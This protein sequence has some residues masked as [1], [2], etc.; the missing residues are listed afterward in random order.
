MNRNNISMSK[1]MSALSF[2]LLCLIALPFCARANQPSSFKAGVAS[3]VITPDEPMWMAGY[4]ARNKPSEGKVHDLHAKALALE[5]EQGTRLVI[6][7]VE[8]IGIP[9]PMRDWL[10]EHAK[11]AYKLEPELLLL[12][13]SH[14]HCGPVIRETRYSIYGNTLYG[15][16]PEQIR[17]SNKYVD[18]LQKKLLDLI[19]RAIENLAPAKLSYT[20]ARAGFAMNRRLITETG[21][22][23]SPNPEG[24]VDHDVP[25]L[26][27]DNPEGK[28]RAVLFGYACHCTTLS[29][30][31]YCGDYAGFAQEYIE[32]A[33]PGTTAMF[34][35]G[36]GGDQNPY[37]RRALDHCKHHG[38][39]LANGVET[40]FQYQGHQINGPIEA[41]VDTVMLDFA[42][43][44]S[45]EQLE[46]K[47]KSKDKYDRRHA[48]VLLEELE[49]NGKIRT[50]YPY[51]V[52]VVRFGE[53]LTMVALA[54]EVVV[55][56]SLRLK[57]ELPGRT[58]WVAGY[59]NDV[60]GYIPSVRVLREGGYEAGGAMRYTDLPGP[61]APSV[62]Q[63]VV[64]KVH[65]LVN[66][67]QTSPSSWNLELI[68][69]S[70]NGSGFVHA[71]SGEKFVA[72]GFNY[73]HDDSGR[74]LEDYWHHEWPTI[75][76][77]FKEIKELGA[78]VVRIH[79]QVSKFIQTPTEP[80]QTSLEQLARLVELAER[81]GLYLDITGL[82]CYHK[83]DVPEW[84][85]AMDEAARWNVQAK[86]WEAIA[87]TCA[88]SP[89]IFCYDLMNE[90]ILPGAE[91]AETDWLA[92]EFGGKHFVQRI[93]LDL[94]GRT[95]EQ[96]ARA[97]VDK[98]VSAIRKHDQRHMITV[99]VI[100]WAHTF[101]NAKPLF[102]SS[103]VGSN[104][105]FVSVHFYPKK[106]EVEKALTA[107]AVYDVGKPLVIEET[108][109]LWCGQDDFSQFF[110]GSREIADGWIGF[111]WGT[112][113][114]EYAQRKNDIAA[115][116][117][118]EWLEF[119][120][121]KTP[122][123]LCQKN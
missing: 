14:T 73:D 6:V 68:R 117:M 88:G 17:Q 87:K 37:P 19:G 45:R 93:T 21:V 112:T 13:A 47:A 46:Q 32:Q 92:G 31:Q 89:A 43:P 59:S 105:D 74:L 103:Q 7:T 10:A 123:I 94:A 33:H 56:Y 85:D 54:G 66:K 38:R 100:P 109:P 115:G 118:R 49:K 76:E 27:I 75:V 79:P 2:W 5:D 20:H 78:N 90:P 111:Y 77:D 110:N 12:N 1:I 25:V 40:A 52:Q 35:A 97:W 95:R 101:P 65:E 70:K 53:D 55:D 72:W 81:T 102:Y 82:G 4:A 16:S 71:G 96:V 9:R 42:E 36:C 61:F 63:R 98:L 69:P 122:E 99:G 57:S 15:L 18:D 84:Y 39:A 3:I 114:D 29:F 30:Y 24:P 28:L 58:V 44:P 11:K 26:R 34:I 104:L 62:E 80:N 83:K 91:K 86:Y 48:E 50:T 106:G 23:N 41:A 116:I 8:L 107:L 67:A 64:A 60:F 51:L 113:I 22:R 121:E 108:S 119:F 120:R